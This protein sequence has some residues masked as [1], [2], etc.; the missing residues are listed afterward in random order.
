[1]DLRTILPTITETTSYETT[2]V[3]KCLKW[4]KIRIKWVTI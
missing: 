1:M 2:I 4:V 3:N